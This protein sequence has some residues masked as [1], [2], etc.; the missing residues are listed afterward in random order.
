[1]T[2]TDPI[3]CSLDG[4]ELEARLAAVRDIGCAALIS[5]EHAGN[6]HHLRFRSK[7]STRARLE[8]IVRAELACCP[9]LS[10]ALAEQAAE[11]VLTIEAPDG[12]E[13]TAAAL[14]AAF[15]AMSQ[16]SR[17]QPP[18]RQTGDPGPPRSSDIE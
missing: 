4:D 6:R 18:R 9:F 16:G 13:A 3:A 5:H 1:M 2:D 7:A 15:D 10:L 11:I 14:A 17:R 12:G 8:E